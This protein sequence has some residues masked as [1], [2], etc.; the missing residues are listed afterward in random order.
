LNLD[1]SIINNKLFERLDKL[2]PPTDTS[3]SKNN[4]D[5]INYWKG[6]KI[7]SLAEW[8]KIANSNKAFQKGIEYQN[9]KEALQYF[10]DDYSEWLFP[11]GVQEELREETNKWYLQYL[12]LMQYRKNPKYGKTKCIHCL[13]SRDREE[14]AI[15]LGI[16]KVMARGLSED[17]GS[18]IYPC[19]IQNRFECPY[20]N[21]EG[22]EAKS[23]ID[24]DQLFRLSEI[25]FLVELA[26]AK[27]QNDTSKVPIK[28]REDVYHALTDRETLDAILEQGLDEDKQKYKDK[29]IEFFMGIKDKV[30]IEDLTFY[31]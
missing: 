16:N 26:F 9:T 23:T 6:K 19:P 20:D 21:K 29:I 31:R 5:G 30:R 25:A 14:A 27:A 22:E 28:N 11:L 10:P 15:F 4:N 17:K 3:S 12:E 2:S 8:R 1:K 7:V 18:S 13:L 24:V